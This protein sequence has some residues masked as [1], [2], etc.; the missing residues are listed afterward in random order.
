M[1]KESNERGLVFHIIHG[2]FVDG[3]GIRT[4]VFLK[5]CLLRCIWCC[6]PEGQECHPQLKATARLCNG[7]ERCIAICPTGAI[8][9]DASTGEK[10]LSVNRV[11]CTDCGKCIDVCYTGALDW[12]GKYYTVDELFDLVKG[13]EPYYRASG[14]GVTLGGGEPTLQP[15]FLLQFVRKCRQNHIHTALDTCGYITT[16]DGLKAF[17]EVDLVLYDIKG[18]DSKEHRKNTGMSNEVILK[19]LKWRDSLRKSIIA[20]IPLIPGYTDTDTNL[21]ATAEFLSGL[22]SLERVDLLGVH[23]YGKVK[24]EQLG[25]EYRLRNVRHISD[26]RMEAIKTLFEAY[27]LKTQIGG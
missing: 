5:G 16:D 2:S 20:R 1:D 4:T 3:Y 14:G 22:N 13:D 8:L 19:N 7:C 27:G 10:R 15:S 26:G 11:K 12:F 17:E 21:R 6:N 23:E 18:I 25:K 9:L 24:Y